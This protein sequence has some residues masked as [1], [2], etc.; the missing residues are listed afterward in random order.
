MKHDTIRT[1]PNC[2]NGLL[3][4]RAIGAAAGDEAYYCPTCH[5]RTRQIPPQMAPMTSAELETQLLS[6]VER[7]M[8]SDLPASS[9]QTALCETLAF[10]AEY[11]QP[12]HHFIVEIVDLGAQEHVDHTEPVPD[13]V[14]LLRERFGNR[15]GTY[16]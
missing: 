10:F 5:Y 8:A 2:G 4:E 9:I 1:C 14:Y 16:S 7:A 3:L 13:L 15:R 6:L 11:E 12:D